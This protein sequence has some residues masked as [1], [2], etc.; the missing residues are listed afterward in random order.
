MAVF[1]TPEE[2]E[3]LTGLKQAKSQIKW[4]QRK[5]YVYE[6]SATGVPV[7]SVRHVEAKLTGNAGNDEPNWA[8]LAG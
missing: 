6:I 1:L 2:L 3:Q 7:V 4:L 8:A 5:G